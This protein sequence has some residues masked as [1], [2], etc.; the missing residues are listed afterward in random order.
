MELRIQYQLILAIVFHALVQSSSATVSFPSIQAI[1]GFS[2]SCTLAYDTPVNDCDLNDFQGIGGTGTCSN[3]CQSSLEASQRFVQRFCSGEQADGN[4]LIGQLFVGNV[5]DFLCGDNNSGGATTAT[6]TQGTTEATQT[7]TS[8][9][10]SMSMATDTASPG[11]SATETSSLPSTLTTSVSQTG[12]ASKTTSTSKAESTKQSSSTSTSMPTSIES[13]TSTL[14]AISS[15]S[16]S[17]SASTAT[18]TSNTSNSQ[19]SGGGSGG[20]SPFDG[21][22]SSRAS[23]NPL[24]LHSAILAFAGSA[25]LF[26]AV[27]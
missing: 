10:T 7:S 20:G 13:A 6:T 4:S 11:T 21:T 12:S 16:K 27:G 25:L 24:Q 3:D 8:A 19:E 1:I 2:S 9:E 17:S 18:S 26:M 5:V 15:S 14:T 23:S 22:F